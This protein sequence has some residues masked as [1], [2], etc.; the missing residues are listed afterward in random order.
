MSIP[1]STEHREPDIA[2]A[3]ERAALSVVVPLLNEVESLPQLHTE[4][5]LALATLDLSGPAEIIYVDDGS[6]DGSARIL[7]GLFDVD[8]RV[9]VIQFR[10][11]FGKSAALAAGFRAASG[12]LVV[13]LDA[14]LQDVPARIPSLL[15]P[16]LND[17][18]DLVSGWKADRQDPPSKTL[19][20]AVFN[21]V[22]RS[23][24]G[25][26]L[27]D[28]NCGFK[29]YRDEV[30]DELT[31]YGELHRYIPVLAHVRGFR[32]A[33]VAVPHRP[34]RYGH[35]KFGPSRFFRGFFDLLTVLFLSQ[36]TRRPLHLFGLIG[37]ITFGLGFLIDAW[38]AFVKLV[39][40]QPIGHRPLLT[41]GVL[42]IIVGTQFIVFG[43]LGE[44]IAHHA[45]LSNAGG[46]PTD[47]SI[48]RVLR[49]DPSADA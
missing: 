8:P 30:L 11:N 2:P 3:V 47:Y 7:Q 20:S 25:V 16:I 22:V 17:E 28:F 27:H 13:T 37:V 23:M 42:L 15:A 35:S 24:T 41:L 33:E 46:R 5:T 44:M 45:H 6:T 31:L 12:R 49:H 34:R 48:R 38:L 19:P 39:L 21:R 40:G 4:I 10:R 14:D 26:E 9:Q 43:L 36:Y 32:V 29:A 1:A 18:A